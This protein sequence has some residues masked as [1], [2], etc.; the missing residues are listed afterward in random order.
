MKKMT[1]KLTL[2]GLLPFFLML[3]S[4][5]GFAQVTTIKGSVVD[6]ATRIPIGFANVY[7]KNGKG[8]IA[9][10]SGHFEISTTTSSSELQ[11]SY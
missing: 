10:S 7:F 2:K 8:I 3:L 5:T 11:V 9:D 4:L 1:I 6:A